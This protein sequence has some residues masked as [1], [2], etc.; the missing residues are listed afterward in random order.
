MEKLNKAHGPKGEKDLK[1]KTE[2]KEKG[3]ATL[4]GIDNAFLLKPRSKRRGP[5]NQS[6]T[7]TAVGKGNE[8]NK[9]DGLNSPM[10]V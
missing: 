7:E 9:N 3:I 6:N 4:L 1:N 2:N 5:S 10:R 8:E